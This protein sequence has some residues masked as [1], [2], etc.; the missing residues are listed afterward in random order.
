[1]GLIQKTIIKFRF[2]SACVCM[3]DLNE[4][5]LIKSDEAIG[6]TNMVIDRKMAYFKYLPSRLVNNSNFSAK[7]RDM[8]LKT[9]NLHSKRQGFAS[10]RDFSKSH[11]KTECFLSLFLQTL[12]SIL[13]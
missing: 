7:F 10:R 6:T 2:H 5:S 4:P 9:P 1:M 3:M 11:E 12:F 8:S 13:T